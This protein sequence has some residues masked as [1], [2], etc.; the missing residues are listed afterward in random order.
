MSYRRPSLLVAL[1]GLA[2]LLVW[3]LYY[4]TPDNNVDS[5]RDG[6]ALPRGGDFTLN[7]AKGRWQLR[8]FRGDV[9]LAYFGYTWCPDVCPT[10]L[11]YMA[12]AFEKLPRESLDQVRGVF[13]SVD[14]ERDN[15]QRLASYTS[16]FHANI[17]GLTGSEAQIKD[18]ARRY[19]VGY[20]I[21]E[22][23]PL[24]EYIV[25][26]SSNTYVI[27]Q[28]GRLADILPHAAPPTRIVDT[29]QRLLGQ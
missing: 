14:P 7:S 22:K 4:W 2:S 17:T 29:V 21:G 11:A 27:D 19:G 18:L 25:D 5:T 26:H 12:Q 9:I 3:Q 20:R 10:N 23:D 1:V 15:V 8:D 6:I 13:V 24:G 16:Y 28:Q